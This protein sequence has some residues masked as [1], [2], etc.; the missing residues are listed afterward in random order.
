M[1][2]GAAAMTDM[3]PL[4]EALYALQ[5]NVPRSE[6]SMAAQLEYD[7]LRPAWERGEARPAAEELEAARLAWEAEHPFAARLAW[8][9]EHP[10]AARLAW[11]AEHPFATSKECWKAW[12]EFD[13][14]PGTYLRLIWA[15]IARRELRTGEKQTIASMSHKWTSI[16]VTP[17]IGHKVNTSMGSFVLK[18]G[19]DWYSRKLVDKTGTPIL[20]TSGRNFDHSAD[21]SISFPD[22]RLRS[23]EFPVRGTRRANAIMTAVDEAGNSVARYRIFR[24]QMGGLGRHNV[25][26][27]VH[28]DWELTDELMLAITISAPWLASYFSEPGGGG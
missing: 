24:S 9:A 10:F 7:Q 23:L 26:I 20:Y 6:L 2:A 16:F 1:R 27:A 13:Q 5:S 4:Q 21:A 19:D 3:T 12:E 25:E 15:G 8:E 14:Q 11:E 17:E 18:R 22:M 28:P